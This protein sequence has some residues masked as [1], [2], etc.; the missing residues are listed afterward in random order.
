MERV[1]GLAVLLCV[2]CGLLSAPLCLGAQAPPHAKSVAV[3]PGAM[4]SLRVAQQPCVDPCCKHPQPAKTPQQQSGGCAEHCIAAAQ[5][6]LQSTTPPVPQAMQVPLV[7]AMPLTVL[8]GAERARQAAREP[9][10]PLTF[11]APLRI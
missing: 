9:D 8:A 3:A 5:V 10:P 7:S 6:P 4:G 2:A 1:V 11:A